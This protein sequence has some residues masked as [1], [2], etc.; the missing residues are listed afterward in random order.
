MIELMTHHNSVQR[1]EQ[2]LNSIVDTQATVLATPL[3]NLDYEPKCDY[4][5][6][7]QN[8]RQIVVSNDLKAKK[9]PVAS[10]HRFIASHPKRD[11]VYIGYNGSLRMF[12]C[13]TAVTP[14]DILP[15]PP[16]MQSGLLLENG[17]DDGEVD[18]GRRF[19][20]VHGWSY[21]TWWLMYIRFR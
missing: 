18:A 11:E 17:D 4:F 14:P 19:G 9:G 6:A 13:A 20:F 8:T 10:V 21:G 1:L 15:T 7:I 16:G 12:Y 2:T 5:I 3:W